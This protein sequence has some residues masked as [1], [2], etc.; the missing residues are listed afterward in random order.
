MKKFIHNNK[1]LLARRKELRNNSTPQ[2][3][4]LW[5]QLKRSGLGYKFRR[6]HSIGSYIVDFYCPSK[7]IVVEVD[8]S[9]HGEADTKDYDQTRKEYL[10]NL[11]YTVIRFWNNEINTNLP[12]VLDK[13]KEMLTTPFPSLVKEG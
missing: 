1:P 3:I 12:G 6:Q 11:G 9:Q 10:N 2:E 8:G 5:Q 13:I 7:K 4:I